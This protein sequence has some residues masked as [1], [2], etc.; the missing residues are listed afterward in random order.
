HP[1][2]IGRVSRKIT[3]EQI[4]SKVRVRIAF[5]GL[6]LTRLLGQRGNPQRLHQPH[7]PLPPAG[8]P[9]GLECGMNPRTAVDLA[10]LLKNL[11]NLGSDP[12]IFSLM[13]A[14]WTL[15]PGVIAAFRDIKCSAHDPNRIFLQVICTKLMFYLGCCEKMPMASERISRRWYH[16]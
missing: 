5:R 14:D 2:G 13:C 4:G 11:L 9:S 7:D 10:V 15:A 12:G 8:D 16:R 6:R 1:F 3:V